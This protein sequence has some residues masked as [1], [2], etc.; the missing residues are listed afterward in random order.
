VTVVIIDSS[1]LVAYL[2]EESGF[3]RI[4]DLLSDGVQGPALLVMDSCNAVL[5]A[6]KA[7]RISHEDA[8]GVLEVMLSLLRANVKTHAEED[9]VRTSFDTASD[10]GL[11]I[12]DSIY[13]ALAKKLGGGLASRDKKQIE[14]ARKLGID[15]IRT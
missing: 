14:V 6:S 12:Y 5:Q 15:I 11:T 3:E 13:L 2:L 7:G 10:H 8:E 4:R 9:L 1:A